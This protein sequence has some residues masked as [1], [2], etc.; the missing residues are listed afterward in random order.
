MK[1]KLKKILCFT[2]LLLFFLSSIKIIIKAEDEYEETKT[3]NA[4]PKIKIANLSNV[5]LVAG[6]KKTI[7]LKMLNTG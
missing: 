7:T 4:V 2:C 3:N 5:T 6:E 1:N